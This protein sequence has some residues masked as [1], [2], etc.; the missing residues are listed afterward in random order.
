[1][2]ILHA[3]KKYPGV[4]GGD[5]VVVA[6]L[7]RLQRAAGHR[8]TILTSNCEETER[9][10]EVV[11]FGLKDTPESLDRISFRRLCSLI[12]L[13]FKAFRVLR[14][15]RPDVIHSHSVDMAYAISLAAR[16]YRIPLVHTF[17]I[18]TSRDEV[19]GFVRN[20]AELRLLKAARPALVTALNQTD[21]DH[22]SESGAR[23]GAAAEWDRYG[24]VWTPIEL[25]PDQSRFAIDQRGPAGE[26]QRLPVAHPGGCPA[27][28]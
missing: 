19:H 6:N 1:M 14:R 15:E 11:R 7:E 18:V 2:K 3:S 24:A 27:R 25:R 26:P 23:C 12:L 9:R 21:L 28:R 20:R 22:L 13:V 8:V 17:H 4:H 10:P 16:V 5:A